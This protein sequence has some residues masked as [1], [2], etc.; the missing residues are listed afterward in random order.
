[1]GTNLGKMPNW[2]AIVYSI[3]IFIMPILIKRDSLNNR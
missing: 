3:N 1:M 2:Q